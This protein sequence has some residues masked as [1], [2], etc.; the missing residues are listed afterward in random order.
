GYEECDDKYA[1]TNTP[2]IAAYDKSCDYCDN[3]CD[4]HTVQG[5]FCGDGDINGIEICEDG[6]T[7]DEDTCDRF[8]QWTCKAMDV[9][10]N[11]GT[12]DGIAYD[13]NSDFNSAEEKNGE[14]FKL[15][16]VMPTPYIWIA[17]SS[18]GK[19]SKLRIYDGKKRNCE[20]N[21]DGEVDCWWVDGTWEE[22]GQLIGTYNVGANPSRTA[23]NVE[24]GDIWIA[25]R[26]SENVTKL[27]ING[28]HLKTCNTGT[29][30][31]GVA[32]EENGDVWI[33]NNGGGTVVK[34]SGDDNNCSILEIVAVPAPYGLAIDSDGN[35]W[36]KGP[37]G[38]YKIDVNSSFNVTHY[39]TTGGYGITVDL[40]DNVW[41]GG[42]GG[43]YAAIRINPSTSAVDYFGAGYSG[44]GLTIDLNNDIWVGTYTNNGILKISPGNHPPA[45]DY[46]F[47]RN[48]GGSDAHG[49]CG[50]SKGN[51]WVVNN[52]SGTARVFDSNGNILSNIHSINGIDG[53]PVFYA[54]PPNTYTYSDMTGLNRALLLRSGT[55]QDIF[56]SGYNNQHWG[57][58][59][60]ESIITSA[61]QSIE[62]FVRASDDGDFNGVSWMA[63]EDWNSLDYDNDL[64]Q[65][66]YAQIKI[67]M[68]SRQRGITPVLWNLRFTCD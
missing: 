22:M 47:R 66:R 3:S 40:D 36:S 67:K 57:G 4:F 55:W 32:I 62:I 18:V 65:G 53:L 64:R 54:G 6:N 60:W 11:E 34:I 9:N 17:N 51:V 1:N 24:T 26:D 44:L 29:G 52:N 21:V 2:C 33:G 12:G 49:A 10:F 39:P 14:Y 35:I 30:P 7:D 48:S 8:C 25:N 45:Q 23:V 43:G 27:D 42:H 15:L 37:G 19:V 56:D 50:D 59:S 13:N 28:A 16:N 63:A 41:L 46:L 58:V 38:A 20:R 31:R 5:P 61:K 68:R